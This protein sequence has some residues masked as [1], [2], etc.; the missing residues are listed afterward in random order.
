[1]WVIARLRRRLQCFRETPEFVGLFQDWAHSAELTQAE[2]IGVVEAFDRY[3]REGANISGWPEHLRAQQLAMVEAS[4]NATP[5]GRAELAR[6]RGVFAEMKR[7]APALAELIAA[8]GAGADPD[9]IR[10]LAKLA[11]G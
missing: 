10:T 2:A 4:F 6:A 5:E 3:D 9:V 1:M 11:R 8:A 7:S